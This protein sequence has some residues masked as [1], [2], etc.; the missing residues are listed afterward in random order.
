MKQKIA[1]TT[2]KWKKFEC[3][4]AKVQQDLSPQAIVTA[5]DK[6]EGKITGTKRQ[7]DVS[8]RQRVG[9]YEI[10]I[11]IECKDLSVPIDVKGVEE[12]IGLI[13]DI[14]ANKGVIVSASG[15]TAAAKKRGE[16]AGL[17]LYRLID[18]GEHDWKT[19]VSIPVLCDCR[20]IKSFRLRFSGT[21]KIIFPGGDPS[22]L[23]STTNTTIISEK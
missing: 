4:V 15:F 16:N 13:Q 21:E 6:I 5:N 11:A 20:K 19:D 7:I 22:I 1:G 9:Q 17:K 14:G 10:L 3:L 8:V 12:A 23:M 18:C 2:Q